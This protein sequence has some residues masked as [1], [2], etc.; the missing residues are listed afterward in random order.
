MPRF[1]TLFFGAFFSILIALTHPCA[2]AQ[3]KQVVIR[4][5][6]SPV[7]S[8]AGIYIAKEKGY[9]EKQGLKV[10]VTQFKSSG[11]ALT[12]PLVSGELDVGAGNYTAGLFNS[13]L[14][15]SEVQLVA[16][17]GHLSRGHEYIALLV[18]EDHLKSGRFKELK[19]LKGFKMGLTA[20]NGV[21]Q[22]ILA[23]R[24]LAKGGLKASDVTFVK[25]SYSDM[26]AAFANKTLDATIQLEPYVT[27]AE[28][29]GLAKRFGNSCDVY[30]GQQSAGIFYS[31]KFIK[32]R[33][34]DAIKF[35][36]AYL[37]GVRDYVRAFDQG[38]DREAISTL[39]NKYV[40]VE[41]PEIW[42]SMIPVGINPDGYVDSKALADDLVWY[43]QKKYISA[44]GDVRKFLNHDF[45]DEALKFIGKFSRT[46]GK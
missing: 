43:R 32:E 18:R 34:Q 39:L 24:F 25:L 40:E 41:K 33:R 3:E 12:V 13:I 15:G 23:E 29:K 14:E 5:G 19:D 28:Y 21:S 17:K 36:V 26:N 37:M 22:E 2:H 27:V 6:S 7:V 16:D 1:L 20:L 35:M 4:V 30:C 46:D 38:I 11:A 8:S 45:I 44:D 9:F 31:K 10:E 42:K